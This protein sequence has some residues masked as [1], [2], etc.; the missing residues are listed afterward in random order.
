MKCVSE[1]EILLF[2]NGIQHNIVNIS[3]I[4]TNLIALSIVAIYNIYNNYSAIFGKGYV[5]GLYDSERSN[6]I[7]GTFA[8]LCTGD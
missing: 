5:N 8:T 3:T 1:V 4:F 2:S 6:E 7:I